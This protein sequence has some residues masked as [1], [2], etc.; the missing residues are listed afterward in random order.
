MKIPIDK[1]DKYSPLE[2]ALQAWR[3]VYLY[4]WSC[5]V[6]LILCSIVFLVLIKRHKT[7]IFDYASTVS[8]CLAVGVGAAMLGLFANK[9]VLYSA[10]K[11]PMLLPICV[12]VLFLILVVDKVTSLWSNSK[13]QNSGEPYVLE[14]AEE[15][16]HES[17]HGEVHEA[18]HHGHASHEPGGGLADV[19]KQSRWSTHVHALPMSA[20]ST[21]P[22]TH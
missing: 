10:L 5:F 11:S 6:T 13:L 19:A 20:P 7:D 3:I 21:P 18:V 8:R 1:L 16:G 12:I 15:H 14:E 4:Y 9:A 17:G 22:A 2:V